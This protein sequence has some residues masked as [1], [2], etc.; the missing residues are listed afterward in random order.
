MSD[1]IPLLIRFLSE[2]LK[3]RIRKRDKA[4]DYEF[5]LLDL[6]EWKLRL[7]DRSPFI[8]VEARHLELFD[9]DTIV[10]SIEAV[11]L[12]Q[13]FQNRVPILIVEGRSSKLRDLVKLRLPFSVIL[14][15]D[16]VQQ[17]T[18]GTITA[19]QMLDLISQQLPISILSPYRINSPVTG[20]CFFGRQSEIRTI[21]NHPEISYVIIGVRRIGKTSLLLETR[22]QMKDMGDQE[23]FF[24]DCSD[25]NSATDYICAVTADIDIR[26]RERMNLQQ[27][28]FFLRR[29]SARG[30]KPLTFFLDEI[31]HLIEFDRRENWTLLR[32]LRSS[33]MQGY[34][35]YVVSGFREVIEECLQ[36]KTP[37]FNFVTE[38]RLGKLSCDET[39]RLVVV[40]MQNMGISIAREKEVVKQ[41][42]GETAGH[43]NFVQ[44]WCYY[45]VQLMDREGRR[46][47]SPDDLGLL[48]EDQGFER[49]VFRTFSANTTELEKALVYSFVDREQFTIRD[50]D[51]ALK[52]Q[53]IEGVTGQQL[54]R[55]CD[56]LRI[57]G[58]FDKQGQFFS[59]AMPLL[60]R[61]LRA[62][63]DV[64]YLLTEAKEDGNL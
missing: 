54:E 12:N 46:Y 49:Y 48:Y 7:S 57:A 29:R 4:F 3:F 11:I 59:F 5:Y 35:R 39:R 42:F 22:R 19:K 37:L 60:P 52:E 1:N 18:T 43:P 58:I 31:D 6:S 9:A 51:A 26:E 8:R 30:N 47:V 53:K 27:F 64:D 28:P 34:C 36:V 13:H 17:I 55:A 23:V 56:S 44:Y 61:L 15:E 40:P 63:Y 62:H 41:I 14:D 50:I 25:F 21:L 33:A 16:D 20:N 32:V 38:L 2:A 10:S 45:L 24:F